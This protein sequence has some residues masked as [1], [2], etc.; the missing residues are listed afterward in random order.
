[1]EKFLIHHLNNILTPLRT[2]P[3]IYG[4]IYDGGTMEDNKEVLLDE[5][6]PVD[7]REICRIISIDIRLKDIYTSRTKARVALC[8][9]S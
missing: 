6:P 4:G 3:K 8:A 1:V 7:C 9:S 5:L 2:V